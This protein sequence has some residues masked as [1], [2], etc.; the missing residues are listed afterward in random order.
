MILQIE[1]E[2]KINLIKKDD[3]IP[4]SIKVRFLQGPHQ[5]QDWT[6]NPKEKKIVRIGRSKSADIIYKDDSVSRIQCT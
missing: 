5:N 2:S 6:F 4:K 1:D 3:K